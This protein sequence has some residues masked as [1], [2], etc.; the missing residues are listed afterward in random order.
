MIRVSVEIREG[1]TLFRV[2]VKAV[3][4]SR[5]VNIMKGY[6]PERDVRVVFPI[7][8]EEFFVERPEKIGP[9]E[10]RQPLHALFTKV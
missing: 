2:P 7:D 9:D 10:S 3:S 4:I 8:P 6:H 5:A 1:A